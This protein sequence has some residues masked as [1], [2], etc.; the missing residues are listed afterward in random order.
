MDVTSM[1]NAGSAAARREAREASDLTPTPSVVDGTTVCSSAVPTPS[2]EA[3][4]SRRMSD[5]R[6]LNR[7]RTP[8]DAGGYSLPL[9]LD[10]KAAIQPPVRPA[11][12]NES[13]V[14]SASPKSPKHRLSDSYSSLSSYTSSLN[15]V[16]HSRFSSMS[17]ASGFQS[18]V[19]LITELPSLESRSCDNMDSAV[20]RSS[21][22]DFFAKKS[23]KDGGVSPTTI[24]EEPSVGDAGRPGSPSDAMLM[25]RASQGSDRMSPHDFSK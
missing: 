1:L 17:T 10:T 16:S 21:I 13:P 6:T 9:T 11:F 5:P 20:S 25:S 3:V 15:S 22:Q 12:Y 14:D 4:P 24:A 7:A 18:M 23:R 19:P 8:W 2:P